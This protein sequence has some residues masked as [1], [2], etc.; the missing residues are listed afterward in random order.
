[1]PSE[2]N[3]L[4]E[5]VFGELNPPLVVDISKTTYSKKRINPISGIYKITSPSN[6]IYIGLS[7][8]IENRIS[9]YKKMRC[10][11]QSILYNS[12]LSHGVEQHIFEIIHICIDSELEFLEAHYGKLFNVTDKKSGLNIRECGGKRGKLSIE[13][14]KKMSEAKS[15]DKNHFFEKKHPTERIQ[16]F[17]DLK[18]GEKNPRYGAKLSEEE[19]KNLSDKRKGDKNP[20]FGKKHS[21]ETIKKI[22]EYKHPEYILEEKS[23]SMKGVKNHFFGKKHSDE[24]K[25]KISEKRKG[26]YFG[27]KNP[28]FGRKHSEETKRKISESNKKK[29]DEKKR[30]SNSN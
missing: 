11:L 24:S 12:F 6:K 26:V 20:F 10:K 19:K 2:L 25:K 28:F 30:N 17:S 3:K 27:D 21:E 23:E 15:G 5:G 29:R 7:K 1:M 22:K 4:V 13:T 8:D 14:K 18:M 16:L 9:S